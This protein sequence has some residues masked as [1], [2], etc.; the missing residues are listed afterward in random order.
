MNKYIFIIAICG[1]LSRVAFTKKHTTVN[2]QPK[3]ISRQDAYNNKYVMQCSPDWSKLNSDSLAGGITILPGWGNYKWDIATSNDSAGLYFQQGINMYYSFHIIEAMG[4]F[5]KAEQFETGNAMIYWAQALSYGPNI[6]DFEYSFTPDAFAAAQKALNLSATC[7]P[8]EKALINAMAVRY[9]SDSTVSRGLLN[10]KYTAAMAKA[11]AAFPAD[12]DI[13]ALYADAMMLLHPWRY[14]KHN[15]DPETWTPLITTVLEKAIKETPLHPGANHY[16]IHMIEASGN[17]GRALESANRLAYLMPEVSHMVHMPSHIY[18]RTGLYSQGMKANEMSLKG[19]HDYLQL[20]PE[21]AN[22]AP[23][24]LIHNLHMQATCALMGAGY[25]YS[26]KSAEDTR[27]SFDTSFLS[28]PA[29]LGNYVQYVYMTPVFNQVRFGKWDDILQTPSIAEANVFA[30]Y[31]QHWAKGLANARM[32]NIVEAKKELQYI[33]E[34]LSEPDMLVILEPYN[35]PAD[36]GKIAE[37][38][39]EGFIFEQEEKFQDAVLAFREAVKFED[40]LIYNEPSDWLLPARQYLGAVLLKAKLYGEAEKIFKEDLTIN[41]ANHWSLQGLNTALIKQKQNAAA[42][43]IKLQ[44]D[45]TIV[46]NDM[47]E[48]PIVY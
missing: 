45:K 44:L 31:L 48:L 26:E 2:D 3:Y 9:T 4:S 27:E 47:K 10:E 15:G 29:P 12:A 16:Y 23:L 6:N 22:N 42:G 13:A 43:K 1:L 39:L 46:S 36:A 7:T 20:Y 30:N 18:I 33:K 21:V 8:K 25:S 34:H 28:F 40:D 17:P 11:Y 14:W 35:A 38:M 5:K 37:K 32:N 41:P 19:Y 24:Y